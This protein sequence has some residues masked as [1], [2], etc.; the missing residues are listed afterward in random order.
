MGGTEH[1]GAF[2]GVVL[3]TVPLLA[4]GLILN[5]LLMPILIERT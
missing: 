4:L 3:L 2:G 1:L 5:R